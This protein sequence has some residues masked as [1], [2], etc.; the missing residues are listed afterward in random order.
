MKWNILLLFF[1]VVCFQPV[2]CDVATSGAG[3]AA[4]VQTAGD[5]SQCKGDNS[6]CRVV[7]GI[8]SRPQV[9]KTPNAPLE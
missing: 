6:S 9:A 1:I 2:G 3:A 4:Q 5:C 7:S 8:F